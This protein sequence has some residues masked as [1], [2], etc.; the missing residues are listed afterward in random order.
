[1]PISIVGRF[2]AAQAVFAENDS[3]GIQQ[4]RFFD[5]SSF[6]P[7]IAIYFLGFLSLLIS[8]L[9]FL[10]FKYQRWKKYQLFLEEMK[11]LDLDPEA[12]GT[13]AWMVKRHQMDE[14]VNIFCSPRIFDEM[15]STEML[16][17]LA[18]AGS[19]QS[20]QNFIDMIY[21]IRN[22]TYRRDWISGKQFSRT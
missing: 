5:P 16:R 4:V 6:D 11:T 13:F 8:L 15:A 7:V 21:S 1:M 9:V 3:I 22:K 14:P 10:T 20:K 17:I 19:I 12:E 2:F 18:S